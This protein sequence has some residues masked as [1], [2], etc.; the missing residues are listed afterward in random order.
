[1]RA[2]SCFLCLFTTCLI[3]SSSTLAQRVFLTDSFEKGG[4]AP[5]GWRS[6]ANIAGVKYVY[7]KTGS[8]GS[9]SLSLQKSAKRYFPIAQWSRAITHRGQEPVVGAVVKVK[10]DKATKAILD[11]QFLGPQNNM[12]SHEWL[13]YIGA[14]ESNNNAPA[15]HDWKDY[16]GRIA[17]PQGTSTIHVAL[18]IY[19]PGR[20]WFDEL[21]LFYTDQ[22]EGPL[23]RP[24]ANSK[25][26][27]SLPQS[28]AKELPIPRPKSLQLS[29]GSWTRYLAIPPG[30]KQ[31]PTSAG[32][33][34]LVVLPG[35]DGSVD[36]HP[37]VRRIHQQAL[38]ESYV[39]VQPVAP[40]HI[41]WP[42]SQS[43]ARYA[44]TESSIR[45]IVED[46]RQ[47]WKIDPD[48]V[49]ALAW[50]S[51]GPA[52]YASL[53]DENSPLT[54]AFIAMS[55]FKPDQLPSLNR[56]AGKRVFLYHSPDDATCPYQMA[57]DAEQ[58]LGQAGLQVTLKTYGGGHG[59]KGPVYDDIR[60][61]MEW[62]NPPR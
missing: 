49:F 25:V 54:G 19:G 6:G 3:G 36:F 4:Q 32:H 39:L 29:D 55:V 44:T 59:W 17:I 46:A 47:Q 7:A 48:R 10:A 45:A 40:P 53:L 61:G 16:G 28:T 9:R 60:A 18:Q 62:L 11:L 24:S 2:R 23:M 51:G 13:A 57:Q 27:D 41:V 43:A 34:L 35:G 37:F 50:S 56:A 5:D 1:M 8:D 15:T 58:K 26:A 31:P 30:S 14:Q 21:E 52:V 12:I 38:Q 33:P 20:V 22:E 42:T